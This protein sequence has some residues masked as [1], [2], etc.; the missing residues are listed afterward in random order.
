MSHQAVPWNIPN[1]P[2]GT[3]EI[4]G[5]PLHCQDVGFVI[6]LRRVIH[7]CCGTEMMTSLPR[8]VPL[9]CLLCTYDGV[10]Q[11]V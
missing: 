11:Y 2:D 9:S 1:M 3:K 10:R 5:R 4:P 6:Y 7:Q 8:R